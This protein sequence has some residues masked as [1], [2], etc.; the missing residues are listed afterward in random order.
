MSECKYCRTQYD[1]NLGDE[2]TAKHCLTVQLKTRKQMIKFELDAEQEARANAWLKHHF[3]VQHAG[4][5]GRDC[6]GAAVR[7]IFM[8]TGMGPATSLECI[9]CNDGDPGHSVDL[10]LDDSP[11]DYFCVNY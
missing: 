5:K 3:E 8:P 2:H 11:D 6:T 1:P 4:F 7:Y 10:T 9:W